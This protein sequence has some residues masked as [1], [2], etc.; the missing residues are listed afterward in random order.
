MT[1]AV[2]YKFLEALA[3][4]IGMDAETVKQALVEINQLQQQTQALETAVQGKAP[5]NHASPQTIF[6]TAD[7][8]TYG[9]VKIAHEVSN[10]STAGVAVSP[11]AVYAYAPD[12]ATTPVIPN[13]GGENIALSPTDTSGFTD[14]ANS[15]TLTLY[16][17]LVYANTCVVV[18]VTS[19]NWGIPVIN[20]KLS[21]PVLAQVDNAA[22]EDCYIAKG[23][24]NLPTS[25]TATVRYII[26]AWTV[27]PGSVYAN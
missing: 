3:K 4:S 27:M 15:G 20:E 9:H 18:R 25:G 21:L 10:D 11:D 19:N 6:G 23:V 5:T 2:S 26:P 22:I 12:R 7:E 1:E 8:Q 16:N 17:G 13:T 24:P 14:Y